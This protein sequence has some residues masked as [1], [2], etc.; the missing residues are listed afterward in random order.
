MKQKAFTLIELLVVVAIIGILAAVGVTTF[1]GFQEKAKINTLKSIHSNT[2]RYISSEVMRCDLGEG[3]F[4]GG[5]PCPVSGK[6]A[7]QGARLVLNKQFKNPFDPYSASINTSAGYNFGYIDLSANTW[8]IT[9]RSC[10]KEGCASAYTQET[11][12]LLE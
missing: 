6:K 2:V 8:S 12:L 5:Q 3:T 9:I 4:A 10:H 1:N 7:I 11:I